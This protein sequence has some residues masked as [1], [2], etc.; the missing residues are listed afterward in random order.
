MVRIY[1]GFTGSCGGREK[2]G[3]IKF[4]VLRFQLSRHTAGQGQS[5]HF[6]PFPGN[7]SKHSVSIPP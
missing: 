5:S 4:N 6:P 2:D 1:G 7:Y 3:K